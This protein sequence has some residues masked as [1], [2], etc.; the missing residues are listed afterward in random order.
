MENLYTY[1]LNFSTWAKKIFEYY[2]VNNLLLDP[3]KPITKKTLI[4]HREKAWR[5]IKDPKNASLYSDLRQYRNSC[6]L[7]IMTR[8]YLRLSSLEENLF[9]ISCLAELCIQASYDHSIFIESKKFM[10]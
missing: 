7:S 4:Q 6:M 3:K 1:T 8:D 5:S 2:F 9:S 10:T